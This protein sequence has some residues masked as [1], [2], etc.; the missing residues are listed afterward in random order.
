[1]EYASSP[2]RFTKDCHMTQIEI[3]DLG[4]NLA[5]DSES[6]NTGHYVG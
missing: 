3:Q 4:L 6:R 2:R 1:M 5:D